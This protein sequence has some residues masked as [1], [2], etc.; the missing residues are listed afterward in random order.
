MLTAG[1]TVA[2]AASFTAFPV[3]EPLRFWLHEVLGLKNRAGEC[4]V[5]AADDW[6]DALHALEIGTRGPLGGPAL[7]AFHGADQPE[8]PRSRPQSAHA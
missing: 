6:A 2:I 7:L 8:D 3:L 5:A 4:V 1:P